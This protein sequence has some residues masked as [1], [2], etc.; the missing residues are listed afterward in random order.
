MYYCFSRMKTPKHKTSEVTVRLSRALRGGEDDEAEEEE[1]EDGGLG[2][3]RRTRR[4]TRT[5]FVSST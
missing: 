5:H 3:R 4:R 2:T 1:E